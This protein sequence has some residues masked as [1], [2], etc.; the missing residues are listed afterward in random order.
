MEARA[1]ELYRILVDT[2]LGR[3][4]P[5]TAVFD[6]KMVG[7]WYTT[8]EPMKSFV[9]RLRS[10]EGRDG[11]LSVSLGHGFPWGD[12]PESG[13][14]L[15]VV[16]NDDPERAAALSKQLGREFW[17]LREQTTT[18]WLEIDAALD[19]ALSEVGGPVVMAD[20][21]DNPGGGAPGDST[22]I[23]RRLLERGV[24]AAVV[25]VIWDPDAVRVCTQAGPGAVIPLR[26][27]G[28]S[29][30]VSGDPVEL[31]VTVRATAVDHSQTGLG[32]SEP[33]GAAA[34]VEAAGGLHLV[35]A[36]V[37]TQV[38]G[39]DAFTGLGLTLADKKLI[40]VKST[41]HFH[42][43]FAPLASRVVYVSTPGALSPDFANIPYR[44]RDL[45]YW[46][47]V[48]D[49]HRLFSHAH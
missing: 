22:F 2:A 11:V 34:W 21:A 4:R 36:S 45:N 1:R 20:I 6:C 24:G 30:V 25:G 26:V 38:L 42:A 49:P 10:F 29:G 8:E 7:L 12:V 16:T 43:Q 33:L 19:L 37:R 28:K 17:D 15:W 31:Q 35:L 18:R 47:R 9:E 13:A 5:T 40:V 41:Q 32:F 23:L 3:A 44:V 14:R 48:A 27:G 46:P 39:T